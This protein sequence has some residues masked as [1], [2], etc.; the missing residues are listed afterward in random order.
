[1]DKIK[2]YIFEILLM[3]ILLFALFESSIVNKTYLFLIVLIFTL[4]VRK[5]LLKR[6]MLSIYE[7]ESNLLLLG[8]GL[9]YI[10]GFYGLGFLTGFYKS[11]VT[12]S[13]WSFFNYIISI[14]GLI[15]TSEYLRFVFLSNKF[16]FSS[17]FTLIDMVLLDLILYLPSNTLN[18]LNTFLVSL[19]FITFAAISNNLLFNYL[20]NRYGYKGNTTYRLLTNLYMYII[21][22]IPD[23]YIYFRSILRMIYPY[24]I[25]LI[26]EYTFSKKI[27]VV[28]KEKK[29]KRIIFYTGCVILSTMVAMLVSNQFTYGIM[30]IGS[31]SMTGTLNKG[32]ATIFKK[33]QN[34]EINVGDVI[35][36][37]RKD[38]VI[39]HRVIDKKM[40]NG[41]EKYYTKGDNNV[42][43]DEGYVTASD[44]VGVS[45]LRI[46]LIGYP[47]IWLREMFTRE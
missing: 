40:I 39:I 5:S 29:S 26:Y 16:K 41:I 18:D 19:G 28:R 20:S 4:V 6:N 10:I 44:V 2:T 25:Y 12:L 11:S 21:P 27:E 34:K 35:L 42:S 9:I 43:E 47:T 7:R 31:G 1:M 22:I 24:V 45:K 30:V 15:I 38:S 36:F 13:I 14:G 32:D 3:I 46:P 23:V 33:C 37:K 8:L 17:M